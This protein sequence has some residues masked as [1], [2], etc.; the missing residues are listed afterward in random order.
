MSTLFNSPQM[1]QLPPERRFRLCQLGVNP[2]NRRPISYKNTT[3]TMWMSEQHY[4]KAAS[5]TYTLVR[6]PRQHVLSQYFHCTESTDKQQVTNR[7]KII[8]GS[9]DD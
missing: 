2:L 1:I 9:L 6:D 7:R 5:N 3:C 4:N 8:M